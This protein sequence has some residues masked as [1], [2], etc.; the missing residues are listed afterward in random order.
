MDGMD[1]AQR[2]PQGP[3]ERRRHSRTDREGTALSATEVQEVFRARMAPLGCEL[4][5][6]A[7]GPSVSAAVAPAVPVLLASSPRSAAAAR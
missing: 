7:Y 5:L 6:L 3:T 2:Y 4:R 1:R